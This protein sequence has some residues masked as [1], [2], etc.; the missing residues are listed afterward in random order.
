MP[1]A[2]ARR[3]LLVAA[4]ALAFVTGAAFARDDAPVI[5]VAANLQ[6]AVTEIA[7][8]FTAD[9][10]MRVRLSFGSTGNLSRQTREGAPFELFLAADDAVPLAL[11]R[12]GFTRDE[13]RVYALG[14]I[15]LVA[16]RG[17][18]L[19]PV[20]GLDGVRALLDAGGI[21]RFAIANPDHAP[22]GIAAREALTANDLWDDLQPFM[23]L[24]ENVSQAAQF[25]LSGN[26]EGGIIAY[27]LA[28][29]PEVGQRGTYALIPEDRHEP[30]RQRMV[31][32][33]G[34]GAVA[35]AFYAYMDEP[36]AREIMERYGFVLPEGG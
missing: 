4:A 1:I 10:G 7:E 35:Q 22:F 15:V 19:D 3:P 9:T 25:A 34:A 33:T 20:E 27:S 26:A 23:V 28:L 36:A 14:R 13:G 8:S 5:A 17:S 32:L 2:I 6:F 16:P 21:T 24:G 31:L 29:A 30:L 18:P 11:H 12:D